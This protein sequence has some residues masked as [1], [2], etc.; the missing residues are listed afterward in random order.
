MRPPEYEGRKLAIS[1][2]VRPSGQCPAGRFLDELTDAE[3]SGVDVIFQRLGDHGQLRNTTKFKK[4]G[5]TD[6]WEIKSG[7]IRIFCFW[8]P[9]GHLILAFGLRKKSNRHRPKDIAR[10]T[11][12][13]TEFLNQNQ[14]ER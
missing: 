5:G 11:S 10:A 12:M 8:H 9:G 14:G 13:R 4:M 2:M 3:R 7:Q 6:I 1:C